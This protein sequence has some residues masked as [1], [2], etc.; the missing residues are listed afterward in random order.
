MTDT[1]TLTVWKTRNGREIPILRLDDDHLINII[2][3]MRTKFDAQA[4]EFPIFKNLLSEAK[5][6]KLTSQIYDRGEH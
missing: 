6:R 1:P 5:R 4:T 3:F 2:K